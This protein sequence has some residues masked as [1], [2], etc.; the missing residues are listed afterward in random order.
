MD[1][2]PFYIGAIWGGPTLKLSTSDSE[3][4]MFRRKQ[5]QATGPKIQLIFKQQSGIIINNPM[6]NFVVE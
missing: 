5:D 2:T 4:H 3:S 6:M 1:S